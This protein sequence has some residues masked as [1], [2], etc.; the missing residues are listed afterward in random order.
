MTADEVS[1]VEFLYIE[2]F[3]WN[4]LNDIIPL[5]TLALGMLCLWRWK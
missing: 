4:S 1:S 5:I 3:Q 2:P